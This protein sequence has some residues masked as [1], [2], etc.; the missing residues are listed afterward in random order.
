MTDSQL[1][2]TPSRGSERR[3]GSYVAVHRSMGRSVV[4]SILQPYQEGL[5]SAAILVRVP[6]PWYQDNT[7]RPNPPALCCPLM[8]VRGECLLLISK[9][10]N[11]L[12][13]PSRYP[14]SCK[15]PSSAIT[16]FP[17]TSSSSASIT[18]P[19]PSLPV[20]IKQK[21]GSSS[22]GETRL[23]PPPSSTVFG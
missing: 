2:S 14:F 19:H 11:R 22:E 5:A 1:S 15:Q 3:L 4:D 7:P 16:P 6:T 13:L 9:R 20:H 18:R 21:G 23:L 12:Q 8:R 17:P 10:S